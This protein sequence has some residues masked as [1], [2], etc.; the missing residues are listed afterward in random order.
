MG[1]SNTSIFQNFFDRCS[2]STL[3][4]VLAALATIP[5]AVA[6][7]PAGTDHWVGTWATSVQ[8]PEPQNSL[9]PADM[10]DSTIRQIVHLSIGGSTVRVHLSNA[11]GT[12]PLH[13]FSVHIARSADLATSRIDLATDH[14]LTFNGAPDVI[15]PPGAQYISDPVAFPAAALSDVALTIHFDQAP[16]VETGHPGSRAT[17][18]IWLGDHVTAAEFPGPMIPAQTL[19]TP[20]PQFPRPAAATASQGQTPA[21]PAAA[22]TPAAAP[23]EPAAPADTT[24]VRTIEHW[25]TISG[26]DVIAPAKDFAVVALGDSITDGH[27]TTTNGNNRWTDALNNK[28]QSSPATR[29]IAV[30]N[31]GIG[32][33]HLLTD[34]LGPNVLARFDR[35]VLAQAGARYLIV[36]EA[37]NDL[38]GRFSTPEQHAALV[39]RIIGAY[40]QIIARAHAAGLTVIGATITPDGGSQYNRTGAAGDADRLAV[41]DWIKAP[42]HFDSVIDFATL[43]ADPADPSRMA[44]AYDSG[45]HL[46][47][48]VAG[49]KVMG[50]AFSPSMFGVGP[51]SA[52]TKATKK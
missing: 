36:F 25:Y 2:T 37:V 13:L 32:G 7:K 31:H 4:A 15:I 18:Y 17:T 43:I 35:D 1:K 10:T 42:G 12:R 38:G 9:T 11:F 44:P 24:S 52:K 21:N 23:P 47:P 40:Q 29:H 39:A 14:A 22:P 33:N 6:Q 50:E 46:H 26:I 48:G 5:S 41:N 19:P 30:L 8:I 49:Y 34:G 45:D 3:M 27:A 28:L 20:R 51:T 16:S